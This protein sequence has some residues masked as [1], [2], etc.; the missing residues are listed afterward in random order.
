MERR[1]KPGVTV[2]HQLIL[3]DRNR[4]ELSGVTDV[5]GFDDTSVIC[6]T[7]LGRLTICGSRLHVHRLDLEGTSLT[8]EGQIDSLN[9]TDVRKGGLFGRLLR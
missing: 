6:I 1:D 9:Y 7:S 3:Q 5:D 2:P 4:L 8:V